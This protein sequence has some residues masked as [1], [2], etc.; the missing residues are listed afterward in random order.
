MKALIAALTLITI[1]AAPLL[2]QAASAAA[3]HEA[4]ASD[5]TIDVGQKGDSNRQMSQYC[6]PEDSQDTHNF[7]CRNWQLIPTGIAGSY[8]ELNVAPAFSAG[9]VIPPERMIAVA[10]WTLLGGRGGRLIL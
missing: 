8:S 1:V 7:Y 3:P 10:P 4:I 9:I 5:K 2:A 6:V